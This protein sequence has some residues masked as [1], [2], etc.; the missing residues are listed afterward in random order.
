MWVWDPA[1]GD[2]LADNRDHRADYSM[3]DAAYTSDGT[4]IV[5]ADE[6]GSLH[7][8]DA[9]TLAPIGRS[10]EVG[11]WTCCASTGSDNRIAV[12]VAGHRPAEIQGSWD[13]VYGGDEW[14]R[15]DLE[16][17]RV[18]TRGRPGFLMGSAAL[19]PD[20]RRVAVVGGGGEVGLMDALS[21]EAIRP[22][23]IVHDDSVAF[24]FWAADGSAYVT[25]AGDGTVALWDGRTGGPLGSVV[26]PERRISAA[27]FAADGTT[28]VIGTYTDA[29]YE[30]D[31]SSGRAVEFA[32][33]LVGRDFTEPEWD[34]WFAP[35]PY[36]ETCPG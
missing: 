10:V 8:I 33:A 20:G 36:R 35:R 6:T 25:T 22:P 15:V 26:L 19:S 23:E 12:A 7:L 9:E 4:R 21:G 3:W 28:V 17:G 1:T 2:L 11:T 27:Q 13:F 30:W 34:R 18:L 5:A 14:V 31:T 24:V 32:C 16:A 29:L